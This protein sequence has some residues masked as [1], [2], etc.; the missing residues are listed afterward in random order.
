MHSLE[1]AQDI[2]SNVLN[3]GIGIMNNKD[4]ELDLNLIKG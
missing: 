4:L 1:E 2:A 3:K